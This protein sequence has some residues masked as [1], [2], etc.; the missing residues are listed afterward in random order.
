VSDIQA[1]IDRIADDPDFLN[2][3]TADPEGTAAAE[4]ISIREDELRHALEIG[5]DEDLAEALHER[6]SH[7]GGIP[8][9][10]VSKRYG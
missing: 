2:R 7:S 1:V 3:L 6:L 4:G 5:A 8:D 9:P 10:G